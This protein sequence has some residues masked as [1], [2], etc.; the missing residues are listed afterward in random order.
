MNQILNLKYVMSLNDLQLLLLTKQFNCLFRS[1]LSAYWR[2]QGL[3]SFS[4]LSFL[5]FSASASACFLFSSSSFSLALLSSS[6]FSLC[7]LSLSSF[8]LWGSAFGG[9]LG[10]LWNSWNG[11]I[12]FVLVHYISNIK[13]KRKKLQEIKVFSL[14]YCDKILLIFQNFQNSTFKFLLF[15]SRKTSRKNWY[16]FDEYCGF[17]PTWF[18]Q[19]CLAELLGSIFAK[20]N[21]AK[22]MIRHC[23][24]NI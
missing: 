1:Y 15:K 13:K 22:L 17:I 3:F 11:K 2:H 20:L 21:S 14:W 16:I 18:F 4:S 7:R 9:A 23:V 5:R 10:V 19:S 8:S 24:K 12:I 6:S